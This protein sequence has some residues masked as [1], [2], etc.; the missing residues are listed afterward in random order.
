MTKNFININYFTRQDAADYADVST[1][2]IDRWI[3]NGFIP[4]IKTNPAKNGKVLIPKK[5][6]DK[7]LNSS[8]ETKES[9]HD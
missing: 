5:S 6:L 9:V 7:F 1:D 3:S 4:K 2:T 8:I